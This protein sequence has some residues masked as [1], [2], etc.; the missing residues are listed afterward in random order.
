M[1]DLVKHVRLHELPSKNPAR[2]RFSLKNPY[3]YLISHYTPEDGRYDLID[4]EVERRQRG[5]GIGKL[6]LR[7]ADVHARMLQARV[8]TASIISRECLDAMTSVY[9]EEHIQ[10]RDVGQYQPEDETDIYTTNATLYR[11]LD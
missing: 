7:E 8:M 6:L 2:A 4:L 9:G 3:G 11:R 5:R 10:V 1:S